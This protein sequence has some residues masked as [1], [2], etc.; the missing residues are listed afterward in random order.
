[1]V[2]NELI[3]I[4][5]PDLHLTAYQNGV[6][7]DTEFIQDCIDKGQQPPAGTYHISREIHTSKPKLLKAIE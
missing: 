4:H 1:M 6:Q 5:D 7:D 2:W 3:I